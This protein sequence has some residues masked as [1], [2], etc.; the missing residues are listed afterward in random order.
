M[1]AGW[2]AFHFAC[3]LVELRNELRETV[4]KSAKD[5]EIMDFFF[6]LKSF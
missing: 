3:G 1:E 6:N 2:N 5:N 4:T